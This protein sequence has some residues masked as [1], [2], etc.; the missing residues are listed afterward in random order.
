MRK[1][2]PQVKESVN[3]VRYTH[4]RN[5]EIFEAY[6]QTSKLDEET[7]QRI[8]V[9]FDEW[10]ENNKETLFV[11]LCV[12][13]NEVTGHFDVLDQSSNAGSAFP[14]EDPDAM[15]QS[16]NEYI[17]EL[18][19]DIFDAVDISSSQIVDEFE[20]WLDSLWNHYENR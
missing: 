14:W 17:A 15:P 19:S 4:V 3:L 20:V 10:E 1:I 5:T 9:L 16:V 11:L 7:Y 13:A 8:E 18:V 12:E 2:N 6:L